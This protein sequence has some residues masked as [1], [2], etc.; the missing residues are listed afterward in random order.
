MLEDAASELF[1]EHTY[2][3]TTIDQIA[4]R[5][6]VSR[7]TFFNYFGAK[8]D[9]LWGELDLAVDRLERELVDASV[10][11]SSTVFEPRTDS[12]RLLDLLLA[13]ILRS[14]EHIGADRVPLA[15]CQEDVMGTH[16]EAR[17]SGLARYARRVDVIT[18]FLGSRGD[19]DLV[20]LTTANCLSGAISAAWSVWARDGIARRPLASYVAE[21]L[22]VVSG[23]AA[24]A[25]AGRSVAGDPIASA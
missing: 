2:A 23:G 11:P 14:V 4:Q 16:D 6:G 5:A 12:S 17:S 19:A 10:T 9:L 22:A 21:A 24:V 20:T 25:V 7:N 1:L 15:L 3:A 18:A 8:S 13:A